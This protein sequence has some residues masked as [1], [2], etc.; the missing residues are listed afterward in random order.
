M[1][2][3]YIT[4][5]LALSVTIFLINKV[6]SFFL[7]FILLGQILFL[8]GLYLGNDQLKSRSHVVLYI[9]LVYGTI[10]SR[11]VWVMLYLLITLIFTL[12]SRLY[13]GKCAFRL[14]DKNGVLPDCAF[15]TGSWHPPINP[16]LAAMIVFLAGRLYRHIYI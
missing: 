15:T 8:I 6:E 1:L 7:Y 9:T 2:F 3:L 13:Y 10:L 5:L 12:V 11:N 14:T 4:V 16:S